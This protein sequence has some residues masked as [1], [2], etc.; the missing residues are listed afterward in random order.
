MKK[1]YKRFYQFD[2]FQFVFFVDTFQIKQVQELKNELVKGV[3][4]DISRWN[5]YIRLRKI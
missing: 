3:G 2:D 1:I 4:T 5:F